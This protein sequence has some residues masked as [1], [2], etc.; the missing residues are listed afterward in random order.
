VKRTDKAAVIDDL[1][2]LLSG[3]KAAV[4][5]E[6][7]GLTVA[8][9]T[10]L[11]RLLRPQAVTL[12]IVK[13]TLARLATRG[14]TMEG[15]E[16]HLTGPTLI[17]FGVGDPALPAKLLVSY[18]KAKPTLQIKAAFLEGQVL[19]RQETLALAELPPREV[20]LAR[21]AGVMRSPVRDLAV[22]LS[23]PIRSFMT[24]LEAVRQTRGQQAE[25]R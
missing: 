9:I 11:R 7:R 4:L 2:S 1:K 22:V 6:H 24:V 21:L 18:A 10:D 15:L 17:A 20:L 16:P 25:G 13:N 14:T 12:K 19:G 8:E 3:A 5:A 23:G